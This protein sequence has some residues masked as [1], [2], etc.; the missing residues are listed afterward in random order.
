MGGD[1]VGGVPERLE[2]V[3]NIVRTSM[4]AWNNSRKNDQERSKNYKRKNYPVDIFCS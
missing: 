1:C 2:A 4:H 3:G